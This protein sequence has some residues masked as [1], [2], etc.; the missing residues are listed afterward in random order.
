M[1]K[2]ITKFDDIQIPKQNFHH[3]K[4]PVSIKKVDNDKIVV[5]NKVPFGKKGFKYFIGYK[6][7]KKN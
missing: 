1:E 5:S 2:S 4:R 6:D 3:H 7:A